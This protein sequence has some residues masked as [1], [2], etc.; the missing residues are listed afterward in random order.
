M[1]HAFPIVSSK[2]TSPTEVAN[3]FTRILCDTDT[4]GVTNGLH[5]IGFSINTT[6]ELR[7]SLLWEPGMLAS[8]AVHCQVH[9]DATQQKLVKP[10]VAEVSIFYR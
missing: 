6:S 8:D 4:V 1:L 9:G 5:A 3:N 7:R 2:F 10:Y